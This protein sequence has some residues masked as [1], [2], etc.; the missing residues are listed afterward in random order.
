MA[1]ND[2]TACLLFP[3]VHY[4]ISPILRAIM[5]RYSLSHNPATCC[6]ARRIGAANSRAQKGVA[7]VGATPCGRPQASKHDDIKNIY[8]DAYAIGIAAFGEC[9]GGQAAPSE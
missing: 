9:R 4:E 3:L 5:A 8:N 7:S 6:I 2:P 1:I